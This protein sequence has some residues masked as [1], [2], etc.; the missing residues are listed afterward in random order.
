MFTFVSN[1]VPYISL[2][3][4]KSTLPFPYLHQLDDPET[5]VLLII[6]M[7]DLNYR[8]I[9]TSGKLTDFFF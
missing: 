3:K 5:D 1:T 8:K 6:F 2:M 9:L 7:V 4:Q